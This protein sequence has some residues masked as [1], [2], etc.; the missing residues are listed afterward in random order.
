[1]LF[2]ISYFPDFPGSGSP[3]SLYLRLT[4]TR[5]PGVAVGD[6]LLSSSVCG[7]GIIAPEIGV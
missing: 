5:P 4:G 1:V 2:P 3:E 6:K 7:L